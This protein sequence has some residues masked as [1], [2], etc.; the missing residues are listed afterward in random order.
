METRETLLE[1]KCD[2]FR[3]SEREREDRR[4]GGKK[5]N[6]ANTVRETQARITL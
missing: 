4:R 3:G 1:S 6:H 5:I 2:N